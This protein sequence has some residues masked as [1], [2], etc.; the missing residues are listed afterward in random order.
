MK[1]ED[2][3]ES[4]YNLRQV[5]LYE[6]FICT[7]NQVR[8]Y[9][10]QKSQ[11]INM[12]QLAI[13]LI[14]FFERVRNVE[15]IHEHFILHSSQLVLIRNAQECKYDIKMVPFEQNSFSKATQI[16]I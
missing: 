1:S 6:G 7:L 16:M 15:A 13:L 5:R 2:G 9:R 4:S 12:E 3:E 14:D 8:H 10:D 11:L